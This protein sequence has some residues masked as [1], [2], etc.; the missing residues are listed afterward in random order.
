MR[1]PDGPV[2]AIDGPAGA[3]KSSVARAVAERLKLLYLD[4]GALYR[5]IGWKALR[6]GVDPEDP[7]AMARLCSTTRVEVA[8]AADGGCRFLVDGKDVTAAI[9][10]PEA[11]LAASAVSRHRCVRD[12]LLSIQREA[13]K[14]GG[15]ILDGRD[16]GTVVFP[17]ADLKIFLDAA[18][19]VRAA[20]RH[21]ELVERGVSADRERV[22]EETVARDEAD[23][24][25]DVAP[26][27]PAADAVRVDTTDLT[28]EQVVER[29]RA[30]VSPS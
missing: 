15:V 29:I 21:R 1:R 26:L 19:E 28:F 18:P 23:R 20:R 17:D 30:L 8:R 3:G 24:T 22:L 4:T 13:G 27:V 6:D 11:A 16:I 9:R 5:S 2:I 14:R 25:R 10:S 7:E 12:H